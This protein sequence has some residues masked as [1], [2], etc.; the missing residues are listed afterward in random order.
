M[1]I[2][3]KLIEPK[4]ACV[5][6]SIYNA[7]ALSSQIASLLLLKHCLIASECQVKSQHTSWSCCCYVNL[8]IIISSTL[9]FTTKQTSLM[10]V[11]AQYCQ[12]AGVKMCELPLC[13]IQCV[14]LL[15]ILQCSLLLSFFFP[16]LFY[17]LHVC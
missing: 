2:A 15:Y 16:P 1:H 4:G 11:S 14:S 8:T 6:L 9:Y 5:Y 12:S 13:H 10:V 17:S 3:N 7:K